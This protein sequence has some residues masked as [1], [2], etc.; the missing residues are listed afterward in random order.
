MMLWRRWIL[1]LLLLVSTQV[2]ARKK[3][4]ASAPKPQWVKSGFG[5]TEPG[6]ELGFGKAEYDKKASHAQLIDRALRHAQ[7]D[8]AQSITSTQVK[9]SAEIHTSVDDRSDKKPIAQTQS[10]VET[11]TVNRADLP[12]IGIAQQ[13]QDPKSCDQYVLVK[14]KTE[15]IGLV[16]SR[17]VLLESLQKANDSTQTFR[18][19][20]TALAHVKKLAGRVEFGQLP[21][22]KSSE[23]F[24]LEAEQTVRRIELEIAALTQQL[25]TLKAFLSVAENPAETFA[26]RRYALAEVVYI[27]Q[28]ENFELLPAAKSSGEFIRRATKIGQLIDGQEKRLQQRRE[29]M[30]KLLAKAKDDSQTLKERQDALVKVMASADQEEFG[31]L[32]DSKSSEEF[33]NQAQALHGELERL[34]LSA[35]HVVYVINS[36]GFSD[37]QALEQLRNLMKQSMQGSF[38]TADACTRINTCLGDA[39][40]TDASYASIAKVS[41][42][43][44]VQQSGF[45][46]GQFVLELRLYDVSDNK[47][48]FQTGRKYT[49]LMNRNQHQLTLAAGLEKWQRQYPDELGRYQAKAASIA[50]TPSTE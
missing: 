22:S 50:N 37:P 16:Q 15:L 12:G 9:T 4:D 25:Q 42:E 43:N 28:Q 49:K 41:L 33:F 38:E 40:A 3:C 45:Y 2:D 19:R 32:P 7:S 30:L 14:L 29:A 48:L 46:T 47:V 35:N 27:A 18:S 6:F 8:L 44:V 1:V 24:L 23:Q 21:G 26:Q 5:Y 36:T 39:G 17:M 10:R 20:R 34:S 11:L 31:L 13:W